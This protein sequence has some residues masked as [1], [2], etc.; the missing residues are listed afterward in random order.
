MT[1]IS[2]F[3]CDHGIVLCA[4]SE[5]SLGDE[6]K[7]EVEKL[8]VS[9]QYPIAIGGAGLGE[10]IDAFAQELLE[11]V[12]E[13]IPVKTEPLKSLIQAALKENHERDAVH[14]QWPIEYRKA[15]Y[16]IGAWPN[17]E[18]EPVLFRVKGKRIYRVRQRAIIGYATASN[19]MLLKRMYRPELPM[20]QAVL[21][22]I[23][24]VSQSKI[25]DQGV[26][27]D[28]R[29]ALVTGNEAWMEYPEYVQAAEKRVGEFI[30][31]IDTLFLVS[32]DGSIPPSQFPEVLR[33]FAAD[34][35]QLRQEFMEEAA[36]ISVDHAL[37]DPEYR[38]EPYS[39]IFLGAT[40]MQ[41]SGGGN[42]QV[43]EES[44]EE[45][46]ERRRRMK[47]ASNAVNAKESSE[48][49]RRLIAGRQVLYIGEET[50]TIQGEDST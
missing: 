7:R 6:E 32:V 10:A 15:Q 28:T 3:Y 35:G 2:G 46:E 27:F 24:L 4:D 30:S 12:E 14:S 5:E 44:E 49:Y 22:A 25:V 38:G 19:E 37:H 40:I 13:N 21:L 26:G 33:A 45:K 1:Y 9:K 34:V 47:A 36:T 31:L 41:P 39:K 20:Q 48:E 23:Y 43:T 18:P 16:L 8:Y 29:V 42:L 50:I 11:S 17:H